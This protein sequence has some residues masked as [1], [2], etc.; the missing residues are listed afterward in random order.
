MKLNRW[1]EIRLITGENNYQLLSR[2]NFNRIIGKVN[3]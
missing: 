2:T 1:K 3:Y